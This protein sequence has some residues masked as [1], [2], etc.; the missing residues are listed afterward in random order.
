M[1]VNFEKVLNKMSKKLGI[2]GKLKDILILN[3]WNSK[4]SYMIPIKT[5]A[6]SFKSG[7]LYII[8]EDPTWCEEL[9]F[10][11]NTLIKK[12]N[13]LLKNQLVNDIR[14]RCGEVSIDKIQFEED[15]EFLPDLSFDYILEEKEK[16]KIFKESKDIKN[17]DLKEKYINLR[18]KDLLLNRILK[19]SGINRCELCGSFTKKT[20]ICDNCEFLI[21]DEKVLYTC[22]YIYDNSSVDYSSIETIVGKIDKN[23]YEFA[24]N[25][26]I[27][28]KKN[29]VLS[30]LKE[31]KYNESL[32]K[33]IIDCLI[34]KFGE[35]ESELT[36]YEKVEII[37]GTDIANKLI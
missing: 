3:T 35:I 31:E 5:K 30:Y 20:N 2:D 21:N 6:V 29:M 25:V 1:V 27:N 28:Q 17:D 24:K 10:I 13:F 16:N 11:K 19:N 8:V 32:K 4:L 18:T 22:A 26:V 33:F 37:F 7:I 14:I 12:I 9:I 36:F 23:I 34:L 15:D